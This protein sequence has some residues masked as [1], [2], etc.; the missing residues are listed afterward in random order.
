MSDS[1]FIVSKGRPDLRDHLAWEIFTAAEV[2]VIL[3]RRQGERRQRTEGDRPDR[4]RGD[5]RTTWT[6]RLQEDGLPDAFAN[7]HPIYTLSD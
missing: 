1:L 6:P 3:D 2:Q 7:F 4:R 5:R